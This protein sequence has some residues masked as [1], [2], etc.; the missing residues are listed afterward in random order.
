MTRSVYRNDRQRGF[1]FGAVSAVLLSATKDASS[2]QAFTAFE[3]TATFSH[4][5]KP[6]LPSYSEGV[7][8]QGTIMRQSLRLSKHSDADHG[9][10]E[11]DGSGSSDDD[12][13]NDYPPSSSSSWLSKGEPSYSDNFLFNFHNQAQEEKQGV[14]NALRPWN[15]QLEDE[16]A[17]IMEWKDSF[18]RNGL[19]D[20]TPPMTQGLNCLMVGEGIQN[21]AK[22]RN[23]PESNKAVTDALRRY[24]VPKLPW[25]EEKGAEVTALQVLM[26]S[27]V[28]EGDN[29]S[30]ALMIPNSVNKDDSAGSSLIMARTKVISN[31]D[32]SSSTTPMATDPN[33]PASIYDCIVDQGLM[34]SV[35]ALS[36]NDNDP[37][38]RKN[39]EEAIKQLIFEAATAIREH[40]IYV[41]VTRSLPLKTRQLLEDCSLE[42]GFEW[43]FELDGIS[44]ET[45]MVSVAR[46]FCTGAM[47]KVGKLSRYQ[48]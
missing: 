13:R 19:A 40:G 23:D 14:S 36:D 5:L 44:D 43:Q 31:V 11:N 8:G 38:L 37:T 22:A 45:Q 26:D 35:L 20:F 9:P 34:D 33:R 6:S 27:S 29:E 48:P 4:Q 2:V 15:D 21:T 16:Q 28:A 18:D 25:E 32:D 3:T 24:E 17:E 1:R 41:L 12:N 30:G 7:S 42:A 46:R 47:P 39:S 10:G